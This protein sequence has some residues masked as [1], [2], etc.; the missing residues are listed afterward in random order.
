MGEEGLVRD[1]RRRGRQLYPGVDGG[2]GLD[3]TSGSISSKCHHYH[4]HY[5]FGSKSLGF[6]SH[7]T[8]IM[9]GPWEMDLIS[10][11]TVPYPSNEGK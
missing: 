2:R 8:I 4:N 9:V 3:L 5:G 7:F 1:T 6:K 11:S 10:Q